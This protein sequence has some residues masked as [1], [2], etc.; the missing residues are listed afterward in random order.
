MKVHE[1]IGTAK[2][3]IDRGGRQGVGWTEMIIRS[4]IDG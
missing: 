3:N 2:G 4:Q 1:A